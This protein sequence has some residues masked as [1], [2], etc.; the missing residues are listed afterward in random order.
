MNVEASAAQLATLR[1]GDPTERIALVRLHR[2]REPGAHAR[3]LET[4]DGAVRAAGGRRVYRGVVDAVLLG[5]D[6]VA[7]ELLIDE[8]PSRE[9]AAESLRSTNPHAG[10]ALAAPFVLA[11]RPRRM[12]RLALR[13]MGLVAR[14]SA[15]RRPP[16]RVS[17]PP[18]S[19]LRA[20]D[21]PPE[22]FGAFLESEP[23]RPLDMLN[24]NQ[25][26]D[27]R[28]YA[29]YGKNTITQLL[30]RRAGPIWLAEALSVVV[31][32][33]QL[34]AVGAASH[35]LAQPW[36]EILLVRYPSRGAMLNM[37]RDPAYQLG[38]PHREQGLA[39][40]ALVAACPLP[41]ASGH[42]V[43]GPARSLAG[44]HAGETT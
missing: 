21:P 33:S 27:R 13:V 30:R 9:L 16:Q 15:A 2:I 29:R 42:S 12:P 31:G 3:W 8:F 37:L 14:L 18:D 20:I 5:G 26:S 22:A 28:A 43:E 40:A 35:P 36:D 10:S 4:L 24:L 19:G 41:R 6:A 23:Q 38:L 7:D 44:G 11:A 17:L 39:R 1:D 25:H 32:A 34:L